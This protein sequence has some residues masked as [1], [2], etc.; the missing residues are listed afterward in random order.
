[1]PK[2]PPNATYYSFPLGHKMERLKI[3]LPS[4]AELYMTNLYSSEKRKLMREYKEGKLRHSE[5][6]IGCLWLFTFQTLEFLLDFISS[7]LSPIR[8]LI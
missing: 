3:S 8:V 1:M 7:F 4:T 2:V 5:M 6:S